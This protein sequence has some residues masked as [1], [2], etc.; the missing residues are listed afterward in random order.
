M[1]WLNRMLESEKSLLRTKV[2][3]MVVDLVTNALVAWVGMMILLFFLL[4]LS[5]TLCVAIGYLMGHYYYGLAGM[6]LLLLIGLVLFI[7]LLRRGTLHCWI[8]SSFKKHI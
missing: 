8:R 1:K 5:V 3:E 6:T 2:K 4:F 7:L